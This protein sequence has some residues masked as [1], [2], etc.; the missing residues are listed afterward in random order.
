MP[1]IGCDA[2]FY[3]QSGPEFW[4]VKLCV[5][6]SVWLTRDSLISRGFCFPPLL[7]N[8]LYLRLIF[9]SQ[10]IL[11]LS[12]TTTHWPDSVRFH[13]SF[14]LFLSHCHFYNRFISILG[15]FIQIMVHS[16]TQFFSSVIICFVFFSRV[17]QT[18]MHKS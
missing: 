3:C 8:F 1:K 14:C 2:S 4:H 13:L 18:D 11:F 10:F 5:K 15:D 7:S 17:Q 6:L 12:N 16:V 9:L